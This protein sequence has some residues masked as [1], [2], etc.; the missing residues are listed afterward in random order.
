MA[1]KCLLLAAYKRALLCSR[2][3][4]ELALVLCYELLC[5]EGLKP[6]GP[7]ERAILS[8]ATEL[9]AAFS[10]LN[11]AL[12][13]SDLENVVLLRRR[14]VRVHTL[15]LGVTEAIQQLCSPTEAGFK[16]AFRVGQPLHVA[17]LAAVDVAL[18]IL[19]ARL[20]QYVRKH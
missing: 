6:Y 14:A 19:Q 20:I 3:S 1:P 10:E 5:G 2:L 18:G 17:L 7:A 13:V 11:G 9:K 16:R 8:V 12:K 15:I 4:E